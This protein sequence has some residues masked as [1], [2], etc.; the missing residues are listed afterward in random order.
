MTWSSARSPLGQDTVDRS[1]AW[2]TFDQLWADERVLR[3]DE[4]DGIDAV[5][6]AIST[7]DD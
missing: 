7:R 5:W 1:Q 6:R 2:R 3:A 4:P